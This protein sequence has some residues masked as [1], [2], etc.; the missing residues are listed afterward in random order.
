MVVTLRSGKNIFRKS[1]SSINVY[2]ANPSFFS[3]PVLV[4][5]FICSF[6]SP[7]VLVLDVHSRLLLPVRSFSFLRA[8]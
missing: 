5:A 1:V 8:K 7:A 6:K 4:R 3:F 2:H